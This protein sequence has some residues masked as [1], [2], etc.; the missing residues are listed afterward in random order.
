MQVLESFVT[1]KADLL[2]RVPAHREPQDAEHHAD[3]D[4]R[5]DRRVT[6]LAMRFAA[7]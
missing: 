7:S 2:H 5:A 6:E 4:Q 1:Q 3:H